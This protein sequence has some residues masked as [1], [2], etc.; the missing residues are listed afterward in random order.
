MPR[1]LRRQSSLDRTLLAL[2]LPARR[3]LLERLARGGHRA[4]DTCRGLR[5]S[6]P[7]VSRHLKVLRRAGL[8]EVVTQGRERIYHLATQPDGLNEARLYFERLSGFWDRA[9][10]AFKTFAEQENTR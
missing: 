5:M 7:A 10:D 4:S 9:L 1:D 3:Q 2:S 6:R 8:V